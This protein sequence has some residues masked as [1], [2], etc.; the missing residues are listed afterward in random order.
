MTG[1]NPKSLTGEYFGSEE[2]VDG[3]FE[4]FAPERQSGRVAFED[5]QGG[6]TDDGKVEGGVVFSCPAPVFVER[7]I[8]LPVQIVLDPPVRSRGSQHH[9]RIG[10]KGCDIKTRFLRCMACFFMDAP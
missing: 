3:G 7:D 10:R 6:M 8:K 4:A 5:I 9:G 2:R 1:Q